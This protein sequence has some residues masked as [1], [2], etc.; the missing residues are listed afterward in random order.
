MPSQLPAWLDFWSRFSLIYWSVQYLEPSY[1]SYWRETIL[2]TRYASW[3]FVFHFMNFC[4]S[5]D[6]ILNNIFKQVLFVLF[7]FHSLSQMQSS[8]NH[9]SLFPCMILKVWE[10]VDMSIFDC[11]ILALHCL[12]RK[13][14]TVSA[15]SCRHKRKRSQMLRLFF[16]TTGES[17]SCTRLFANIF[18]GNTW[19]NKFF[20]LPLDNN[21]LCQSLPLRGHNTKLGIFIFWYTYVLFSHSVFTFLQFLLLVFNL[22]LNFDRLKFLSFFCFVTFCF[23]LSSNNANG[24]HNIIRLSK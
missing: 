12:K 8:K 14:V 15:Y 9:L 11:K 6:W 16:A 24:G 18:T 4:S 20:V 21:G 3:P 1:C 10:I 22:N 7:H 5:K 17:S 23:L 2:F 19:W 13:W